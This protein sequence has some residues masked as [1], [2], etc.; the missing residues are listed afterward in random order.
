VAV[1]VGHGLGRRLIAVAQGEQGVAVAEFTMMSVLLLMLLFG[2]VQVAAYFYV[3]N[4]VAAGAADGA[5]YAGNDGIA[6]AD[7]A[8]RASMLIR[9]AAAA[10]IA[11]DIDCRGSDGEDPASGLVEAVVR[12][13]GPVT[14]TFLPLAMPLT[15]DV[16]AR[17]V[18][19]RQP[20]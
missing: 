4:I 6:V 8:N 1:V 9:Q 19:E 10:S 20:P 5:R 12:C 15:V 3:R 14:L 16:T 2:V 18:K 7:G 13:R 17:S 11:R